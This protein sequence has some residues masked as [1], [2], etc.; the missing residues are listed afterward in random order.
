MQR[1]QTLGC[2]N[3]CVVKSE[4]IGQQPELRK[5]DP[6]SVSDAEKAGREP[7][8]TERINATDTSI[9]GA[10]GEDARKAGRVHSL[11]ADNLTKLRTKSKILYMKVFN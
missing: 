7:G 10:S 1:G 4:E 2:I 5:T 11:E 9:G 6:P 3:S 8:V